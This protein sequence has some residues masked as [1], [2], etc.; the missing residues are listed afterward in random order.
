M[1]GFIKKI[2]K[3]R[4]TEFP[5]RRSLTKQDGSVE[6][7]T[8]AR[9]E[10]TVSQEGDAFSAQNMN[11]LEERVKT[12]FDAVD[13]SLSGFSFRKNSEGEK[14]VSTDGGSTWENFSS[15]ASLLWTNPNPNNTFD[16]QTV[17]LDLSAYEL[18]GI[19]V[20]AS[21][22]NVG[23][24]PRVMHVLHK[25]NSKQVLCTNQCDKNNDM[26]QLRPVTSVS[27]SGITFGK[28][29]CEWSGRSEQ[30]YYCIPYQIF[31][32]KKGFEF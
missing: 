15:G 21:Y 13:S 16:A 32:F 11:D 2:W 28:A 22:N 8:V 1:S 12:A 7:V 19:T 27:D 29:L 3:D 20:N 4:V 5:T 26:M 14:E 9:E 31:G 6:L 23:E 18:I 25:T 24:L 30:I 10:G 17:S